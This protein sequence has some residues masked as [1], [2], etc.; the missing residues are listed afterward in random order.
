MEL[1]ANSIQTVR[2]EQNVVFT[3]TA[4]AGCPSIMHREGSGLVT[5]RGLTQQ[6][7]ARFKVMFGAN[8]AIPAEQDLG[9]ISLALTINGEPIATTT[10][11]VTP[12]ETEAYFNVFSATSID[13]PSGC[14]S[15]IAVRNISNI[16]ILVGNA[17]LIVERVA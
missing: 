12:N 8:I 1:V 6:C 14:C 9:P 7:R 2:P 3:E 5:V 16:P 11:I 15:Q 10:M 13:V 4:I 17:N